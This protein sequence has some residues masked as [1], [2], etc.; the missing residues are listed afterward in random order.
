MGIL[1]RVDESPKLWFLNADCEYEL[2]A[3]SRVYRRLPTIERRL[4]RLAPMLLWLGRPGDGLVLDEPWTG[5]EQREAA[6]RGVD[7]VSPERPG[8]QMHRRFTPWCWT[9][10]AVALGARL[11]ALVDPVPAD[12]VRR[13]NSKLFSHAI[14]REL[15]IAIPGAATASSMDEL[16]DAMAR[17]CPGSQDKWVVKS[18]FGVAARERVLGR[19]PEIDA[20]SAVWVGRRFALGETLLFE[21]WLDVV[22]EYGV[23]IHV[24]PDATTR[25]AGISDQETNGAGTITGYR[26]GRAP[27]R[28]R[29]AELDAIAREVGARLFGEGY[30]GPA[31]IDALEHARGVRPLLEINARW[32]FGFVALAV[33]R[34]HPADVGARWN[35]DSP[36][37]VSPGGRP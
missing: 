8:N 11:G 4:R 5:D 10:S 36:W 16:S 18:P 28:E 33:E 29:R 35:P 12:V 31:G 24:N 6:R 22:R 25:V 15:G 9:P 14:E 21:P 34:E 20:A 2:A 26:L 7:L 32:T 37:T 27:S 30:V 19:G 13:V 1:A 23:A 17:G 3:G